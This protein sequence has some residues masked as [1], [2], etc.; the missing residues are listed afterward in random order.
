MRS[1]VPR[2]GQAR[3]GYLK[4]YAETGSNS[5]IYAASQSGLH[6]SLW[7]GLRNSR[8]LGPFLVLGLVSVCQVGVRR[9]E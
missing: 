8:E 6:G 3:L 4:I 1:H 9:R 7:E 2:P 5:V